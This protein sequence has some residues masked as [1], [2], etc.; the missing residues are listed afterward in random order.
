MYSEGDIW[1]GLDATRVDLLMPIN[2]DLVYVPLLV[3]GGVVDCVVL[4]HIIC[5]IQLEPIESP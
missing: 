2:P 5:Y 1:V 3:L 4:T